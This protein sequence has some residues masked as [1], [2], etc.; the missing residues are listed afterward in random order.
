MLPL[1]NHVVTG[2]V[3]EGKIDLRILIFYILLF[4][5]L[6]SELS[7]PLILLILVRKKTTSR[8]NVREIGKRF[9]LCFCY[10]CFG[11][12]FCTVVFFGL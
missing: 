8:K 11:A 10:W 4:I 1:C 9:L 3:L 12:F 6:Y 2:D 7:F 5:A